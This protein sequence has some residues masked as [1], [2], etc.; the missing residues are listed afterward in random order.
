MGVS[1]KRSSKKYVPHIC[2]GRI[3]PC[4]IQRRREKVIIPY[5]Y[6]CEH[7]RMKHVLDSSLNNDM[8]IFHKMKCLVSLLSDYFIKYRPLP[9]DSRSWESPEQADIV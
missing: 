5:T 8:Q 7:S 4:P 9:G 3:I 1:A 2:R 6:N